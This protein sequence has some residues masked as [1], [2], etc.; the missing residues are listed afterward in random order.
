MHAGLRGEVYKKKIHYSHDRKMCNQKIIKLYHYVNII[1]IMS[2]SLCQYHYDNIIMSTSLCQYHY[3]NT[4]S[5]R[6]IISLQYAVSFQPLWLKTEGG[7]T[8]LVAKMQFS[9]GVY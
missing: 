9:K 3:V 2:I 5:D 8:F 1:F 6:T 4:L 7:E